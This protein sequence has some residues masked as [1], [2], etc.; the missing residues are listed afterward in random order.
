MADQAIDVEQQHVEGV[1]AAGAAAAAAPAAPAANA[2]MEQLMAQHAAAQAA[3]VIENQAQLS[4]LL[5]LVK[6][7][8]EQAAAAAAE[9]ALDRLKKPESKAMA[10]YLTALSESKLDA[11]DRTTLAK[12]FIEMI[13][14][15][16]EDADDLEEPLRVLKTA[17]TGFHKTEK[18]SENT[19]TFPFAPRL[20]IDVEQACG[21]CLGVVDDARTR[22][23]S[24]LESC[25][26]F[27]LNCPPRRPCHSLPRSRATQQKMS[28]GVG[29]A[30]AAAAAS[31][32][33]AATATASR[34]TG[35]GK[36]AERAAPAAPS[37]AAATAAATEAERAKVSRCS[38]CLLLLRAP[39]CLLH[40]ATA[41]GCSGLTVRRTVGVSVCC[42]S[43]MLR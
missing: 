36:K 5:P 39:A 21:W 25:R 4:L 9:T 16:D 15:R 41:D 3:L 7:Q 11:S 8:T 12:A 19:T 27:L 37:A 33:A 14:L 30:A 22:V 10:R 40:A 42:C 1:A 23:K 43:W 24:A 13:G 18:H 26:L 34:S 38:A 35:R 2:A 32:S 20:L 6:L 29:G 17:N 28:S 31:G